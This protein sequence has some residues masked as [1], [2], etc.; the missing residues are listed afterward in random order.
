LETAYTAKCE[1][2]E[3][4]E[5]CEWELNDLW[6]QIE[7]GEFEIEKPRKRGGF[8]DR[9]RKSLLKI[10]LAISIHK[11]HFNPKKL[12]NSAPKNIESATLQSGLSVTDETI[13][14]LLREAVDCFPDILNFFEGE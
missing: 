12:K 4:L 13:R 7:A 11:Y 8:D 1:R 3:D 6:E 14:A 2:I 5:E 10:I 9:K